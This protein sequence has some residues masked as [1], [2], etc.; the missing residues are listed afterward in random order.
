MQGV[1]RF[2]RRSCNRALGVDLSDLLLSSLRS[3]RSDLLLGSL[4]SE[5][6]DLLLGSLR[7]DLLNIVIIKSKEAL[8]IAELS[9]GEH[10]Y[11]G[12]VLKRR[13]LLAKVG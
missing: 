13:G 2:R 5:R 7:S 1:Q 8:R 6:S 4:R 9:N 12:R 10:E 3:E 11:Q